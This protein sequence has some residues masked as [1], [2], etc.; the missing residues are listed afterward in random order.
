MNH[1][2]ENPENM[3]PE[4]ST[5]PCSPLGFKNV[6]RLGYVSLFTDFSTEMIL[7][8]LPVFI[9]D[10]LGASYV[11]VG[12]IE[13][14]AEAMNNLFRILTG[15][16]TDRLAKRKPL[17]LLGY[18]LS[19]F[20]KPLFA[21]AT[22]WPQA[23]VVRVTD[24]AGKGTRTSPRDAL[25]S[26]SIAKSEGGKAFGVHESLDQVGAVLGPLL[27]FLVFPLIGF[28]GIFWLSFAPA[29]V[30]LLILV[31]FV[32]EAVGLKKQTHL[33]ENARQVL[34][35][36]FIF[37]LVALGVFLVGAYNFSFI[38]LRASSLGV[39]Y[40][41]V[42]LVYVVINAVSVAAAFPCGI[43]ADRIGKMP[44]LGLSYIA[45][46]ATSAAGILLVGS[47]VY[48][49]AVGGLF[50][51]YLGISD[52]VQRAIIPDFTK[53]ELKGTA[54]AFY[55]LLVGASSFL[56]NSV[57]GYLWT[58]TSSSAAFEYSIVTSTVG[59]VALVFLL[60]MTSK[61]KLSRSRWGTHFTMVRSHYRK[62]M[63]SL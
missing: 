15:V 42:P 60:V 6:I 8:L 10:Q 29:V 49:F 2:A 35:R 52:T 46:I 31:F 34:D 39:P 43:L 50:G 18:A 55:Y 45:F 19:S 12:L 36:R 28:R 62:S 17:V 5:A 57:F 32:E 38:L 47:W 41:Q 24:R 61:S 59:V 53:S 7:G 1:N 51:I 23:M 33:F 30:S 11:I 37:F 44:V 54:Y 48:G 20:A 9:H 3:E 21:F 14:S 27:A 40:G 16:I 4:D 56:A 25:I 58:S 22:T 26:D 13:G 63:A